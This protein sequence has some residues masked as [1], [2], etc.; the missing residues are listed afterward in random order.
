MIYHDSITNKVSIQHSS[1]NSLHSHHLINKFS[2]PNISRNV[3][4]SSL[5]DYINIDKLIGDI[6][7]T[8]NK[9]CNI[10]ENIKIMFKSINILKEVPSIRDEVRTIELLLESIDKKLI[11]TNL[12]NTRKYNQSIKK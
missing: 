1:Q 2:T 4:T 10:E 5:K 7:L 11:S 9:D 6:K 8:P 12:S 3:S